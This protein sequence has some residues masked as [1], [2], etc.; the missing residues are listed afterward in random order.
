MRA[1]YLTFRSA[2]SV[3]I[4]GLVIQVT[5]AAILLIY[6]ILAEHHAAISAACYVGVGA[7]A[8]LT[9]AI[10]YDQHRRE[11]VEA[12]EVEALAS[13]PTAGS[14]VFEGQDD[15]RPAARRLAGLY[16]FFVPA[17]SLLIGGLWAGLGLWRFIAGR[18][19][20]SADDFTPP[21]KPAWGLGLGLVIAGAGFVFARYAAGMAKQPVWANLRAG[22]ATIVGTASLGL[23]IAVGHFVDYAGP[24]IVVRY[25]QVIAPAF[26]VLIGVETFFHFLLG[27]YRPRKANEI[28]RPAFDSRLLG[29]LAAPDRIAKS[30]SDAINYQLGFD[31]TG[32]WFYRLLS[33]WLMPLTVF[34]LLIVW[35]MSSVAI[36]QPHQR[37]MLLRF[38][39]VTENDLGPGLHFKAPWP[40]DRVYIPEYLVKDE[41]GRPRVR[42]YTATGLRTVELGSTPPG[43]KEAILWTNEHAGEEV[44]QFV[45]ATATAAGNGGD[46][47]DMAMVSV[48][49]PL[50]YAV[51]DVQ[52]FDELTVPER[53]DDLLKSVAQR[54]LTK[55][56]QKVTLDEVL[57]GERSRI[58]GELR[59]LV[60]SAFDALNPGP[61]GKPR[62]AGVEIVFLGIAGAHPPRPAA[63]AFETPVQADQRL[64]A[65][66]QQAE[67]DAIESL[68]RVA[69]DVTLAR[70]IVES[71]DELE[72]MQHAK[73]EA[74]AIAE[75]EVRIQ[76]LLE[77]AGGSAA[78]E[79]SRASADR[80]AR[81]MS[82]RGA[83][84]QY[85]GQVAMYN[86]APDLY[87]Y[88]IYFESLRD[89]MKD[90]RVYITSDSVPNSRID[91][92]LKSRDSVT[93]VFKQPE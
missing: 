85:E 83:A 33:K 67:A 77:G 18:Q 82:A 12:M 84:L 39:R 74:T 43:T 15:F 69:G 10:V 58:S 32:G 65:V 13:A 48:E 59:A 57:G 27:L 64:Q 52:L 30:I 68:A 55:Y 88:S 56:F 81:H 31:V 37:A 46:L 51:R 42:D 9:L 91:F 26:M 63:A 71:L 17:M 41:R 86:A 50:Q 7:I 54:E 5:L 87:R 80:W 66:I 92:D 45:K 61:D 16:R 47:T 38:G 44:F 29:L 36:V 22:A 28:P 49:I 78:S 40:I 3:S 19:L 8:W 90:A 60:Q 11:R 79:L 70:T 6:G 53:R 21:T 62:G 23:A 2:A 35:G 24:D 89:I 14:S 76:R 93:D 20:V 72:A 75:Q 73:G 34:G 25:M 4:K 1:D